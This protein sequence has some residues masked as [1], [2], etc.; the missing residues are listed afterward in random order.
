M[1]E[2]GEIKLVEIMQEVL[3]IIFHTFQSYSF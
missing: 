1:S 2:M 3:E